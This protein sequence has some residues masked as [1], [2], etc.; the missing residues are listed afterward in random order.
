MR[1][2]DP[3]YLD[4][5]ATTPV[6]PDVIE[7]LV[8]SLRTGFGNPSSGYVYG[9]RA[10]EA[11]EQARAQVAALIG[12]RPAEVVFTGGGTEADNLAILGAARAHGRGGSMAHSAVEHPAVARPCQ[13]LALRG[14]QV[15]SIPV[16]E[17]GV[18]LLRAAAAGISRGAVMLS[19]MHSNNEVGTIQPIRE[20]SELAHSLGALMHTDAAQSIGKVPVDVDELGVDALTI[21]GHKLYAPKGVG[22]L[23]IRQGA[24]IAPIGFGGGQEGGMRPGTE[25]V[26]LIVALGVACEL[27]GRR[28]SEDG[29]RLSALRD[30]LWS[31]LQAGVP[32]VRLN[33]HPVERLPNTLN[34]SFPGVRGSAVLDNAASVVAASTGSACHEGDESPSAV[35]T[36]MGCSP[37][38]AL[39]AVRLSVGRLTTEAAVDAAAAAL[40]EA[41]RHASARIAI[42]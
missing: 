4:F 6:D 27:A 36:A 7:A 16:D 38:E 15:A 34:V 20:L 39:G 12:A 32:G 1:S 23:Y 9:W 37:E 8:V 31:G 2:G 41:W 28:L 11:V 14:W 29:A 21:A 40:V 13:F 26:A 19:V 22:A 10:R 24:A 30:R 35:L 5:N 42:A 18:V 3:I 33:G 17:H 25:N